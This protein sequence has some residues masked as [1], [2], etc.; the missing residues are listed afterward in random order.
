MLPA[1]STVPFLCSYEVFGISFVWENNLA[2]ADA[3]SS[4]HVLRMCQLWTKPMFF[5]SAAI[6]WFFFKPRQTFSITLPLETYGVKLISGDRWLIRGSYVVMFSFLAWDIYLVLCKEHSALLL[7]IWTL[8]FALLH[9]GKMPC[10]VTN[11]ILTCVWDWGSF[12]F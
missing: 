12:L 6:Y 11:F 5:V 8:N 7:S 10:V 2:P 1:I 9:L 4:F 3:F